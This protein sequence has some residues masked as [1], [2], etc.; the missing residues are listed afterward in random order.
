LSAVRVLASDPDLLAAVEDPARRGSAREELFAGELTLEAGQQL[1]VR[2][3]ARSGGLGVLILSGYVVRE[4]SISDRV[5]AELTGPE[6][7]LHASHMVPGEELLPFSV[8]WSALVPTRLAV[9]DRDFSDRIS[10][11]P[12]IVCALFDRARRPGDRAAFGHVISRLPTVD[13]RLLTSLWHWASS[14]STVTSDGVRLSVPLSHERLA[15]LVGA[16]RPTV[17]A[18]VGRLRDAGYVEQQRDCSWLLLSSSGTLA[19]DQA[20]PGV[21]APALEGI[22]EPLGFGGKLQLPSTRGT[23]ATALQELHARLAEQRELLRLASERH[24]RQLSRLRDRSDRL[25]ATTQLSALARLARGINEND[26]WLDDTDG[27]AEPAREEER[28]G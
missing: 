12:E 8:R 22:L 10:R 2:S 21:A 28:T 27:V 18:A 24:Q 19:D 25:R 7:V 13:A 11:W 14:W 5:A 15:R 1:D 16:R 23:R 20:Q 6:D 3:I 17:T 4:I 9:L 26:G